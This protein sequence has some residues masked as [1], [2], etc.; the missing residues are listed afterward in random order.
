MNDPLGLMRESMSA[1]YRVLAERS[2]G[3]VVVERQGVLASVVPSCPNQSVVNAVVYQDAESLRTCRDELEATYE[4]AGVDVWRVWVPETDRMMAEWLEQ[5]G[6][7]LAGSARAMLMDLIETN[8]EMGDHLDWE[9]TRDVAALAA[10]NEQAYGLPAGEF[11]AALE[12][13]AR[14][15]A[16]LYFAR[17]RGELVACVAAIDEGSDC[18]IYCV[19]TKPASRRL[20]LASGLMRCALVEAR[21][22]GCTTSSLQSSQVGFSVYRHLGY[23]DI[24]GLETWEHKRS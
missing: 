14:D 23:H 12:G 10:L 16:R 21:S 22:R 18:G 13:L 2:H 1:F 24:C 9:R 19:A 11:A 8:L 5:S 7:Q 4:Q 17:E 20:G 3:G 6:H 15:P